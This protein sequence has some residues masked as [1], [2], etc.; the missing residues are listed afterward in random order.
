MY[1]PDVC[2]VDKKVTFAAGSKQALRHFAKRLESLG[3]NIVE[4]C[5]DGLTGQLFDRGS[6]SIVITCVPGCDDCT[7]LLI[8]VSSMNSPC[9]EE[10]TSAA[11]TALTE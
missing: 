2:V 4:T 7:E 3:W 10:T 9:A 1:T 11:L 5:Q 6:H 8:T